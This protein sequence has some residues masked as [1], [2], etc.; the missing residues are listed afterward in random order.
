MTSSIHIK[1]MRLLSKIASA[2]FLGIACLAALPKQVQANE[3]SGLYGPDLNACQLE[4]S[5]KT[6]TIK[7][8]KTSH[9]CPDGTRYQKIKAGGLL[10]KRTVAQG[11]F[12][13]YQASNLKINAQREYEARTMNNLNQ[14]QPHHCTT[15][16]V[17]NSAFTNCF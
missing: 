6:P 16:L 13:D 5:R 3:C 4:Q 15:N 1:P 17:G 2:T 10:F 11:C 12:T 9:S 7:T 8:N 14:I